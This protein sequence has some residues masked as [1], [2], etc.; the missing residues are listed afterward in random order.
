MRI[1]AGLASTITE[2]VRSSARILKLGALP[3]AGAGC[4]GLPGGLP[5]RALRAAALDLGVEHL[6]QRLRDG[7]RVGVLELDDLDASLRQLDVEL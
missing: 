7:G 3:A 1:C 2:L 6:L 5:G 4:A